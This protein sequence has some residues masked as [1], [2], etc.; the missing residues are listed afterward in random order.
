[1]S[2]SIPDIV[3]RTWRPPIGV[4]IS[5]ADHDKQY[6]LW[7]FVLYRTCYS[8]ESNQQ[9]K[10]L[11]DTISTTVLAG[12]SKYKDR[13]EDPSAILRISENFKLDA[14]SD[15]ATLDSLTMDEVCQIYRNEMGGSPMEMRNSLIPDHQIFLLADEEVLQ[16]LDS[17][18]LKVVQA[19]PYEDTDPECYYQW[20]TVHVRAL[21]NTWATLGWFDSGL[22]DLIYDEQPGALWIG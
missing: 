21:I 2:I 11:I 10:A 7:G 4:E 12:L 15:P 8:H 13:G 18:V 16:N 5:P 22:Y 17:G 20:M 14:R 6:K 9:W 3:H 1:M 19:A